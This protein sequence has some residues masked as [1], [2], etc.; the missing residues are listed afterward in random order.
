MADTSIERDTVSNE[1][2]LK[3]INN[4]MYLVSV[5]SADGRIDDEVSMILQKGRKLHQAG[6]QIV[7]NENAPETAKIMMYRMY[8]MSIVL[9]GAECWRM[10]EKNWCRLQV[11]EIKFFRA[12]NSKSR[13]D[14]VRNEIL[15]RN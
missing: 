1:E 8:Q 6:K 9:Y 15:D 4:F 5:I 13:R 3:F 7:W 2:L 14:R 11:G 12:I 10:M